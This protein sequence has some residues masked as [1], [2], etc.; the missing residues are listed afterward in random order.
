MEKN[1]SMFEMD[2]ETKEYVAAFAAEL[3]RRIS[4]SLPGAFTHTCPNGRVHEF[5]SGAEICIEVTKRRGYACE[6]VARGVRIRRRW[7]ESEFTCIEFEQITPV[8]NS[9]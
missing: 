5:D 1:L 6:E 7:F 2:A 9:D 8:D 4:K 3:S